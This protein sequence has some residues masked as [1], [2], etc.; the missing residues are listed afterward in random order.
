MN[1]YCVMG[2]GETYIDL[3]AYSNHGGNGNGNDSPVSEAR[4]TFSKVSFSKMDDLPFFVVI[5]AP[6]D[7]NYI[8][9]CCT[10]KKSSGKFT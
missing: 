1:V 10:L 2:P 5:L 3:D 8:I 7:R 4:K 9:H 6:L